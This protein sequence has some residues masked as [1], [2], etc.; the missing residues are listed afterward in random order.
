QGASA[1]TAAL[2]AG[3]IQ[4]ITINSIAN[5]D[6]SGV[7]VPRY[8]TDFLCFARGTLIATEAGEVPVEQLR[9]GQRVRTLDHGL[10]PLRMIAWRRVAADGRMAPVAIAPGVIGNRR[11]LVLSPQHRVLVAGPAAELWFAEP[12]VLVPA[13]GLVDGRRAVRKA[14]GTV[15][16]F[17]LVC[18]RHE[19]LFAEGAPAESLLVGEGSL[20]RMESALREEILTLFPDFASWEPERKMLARPCL[21]VREAAVLSAVSPKLA[22]LAGRG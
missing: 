8:P 18:D 15:D 2:G 13:V 1:A 12:E 22:A 11:E 6:Y 5:A 7:T 10:Q 16:Y 21:T 14:G 9:I 3:P 4:S 19:V 17:H 20:E